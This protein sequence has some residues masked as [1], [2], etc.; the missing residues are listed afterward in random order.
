MPVKN[1]KSR[2]MD[3]ERAAVHAAY[4]LFG[5]VVTRRAVRTQWQK[6]DFFASDVVGKKEDGSHVYIQATAG[7][8]AAVTAR[9]RKLEKYPWH[10]TDLVLLFQL[11]QT[12]D[13]ASAR[14][15]LWFF[16]IH[17]Y[18][19]DYDERTLERSW[20]TYEKAEP[21]PKEWFKAYKEED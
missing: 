3:A 10:I 5:C 17:E 12:E 1:A 8:N 11:V 4:K 16:R 6:V 14:R 13:P 2:R 19:L 21:I 15:K 7:Q 20:E 9:R 18:V